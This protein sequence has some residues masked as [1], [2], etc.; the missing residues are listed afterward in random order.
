MENLWKSKKYL[1]RFLGITDYS[2]KNLKFLYLIIC[3]EVNL[4]LQNN[5]SNKK[6]QLLKNIFQDQVENLD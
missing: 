6:F 2:P 4:V 1:T 3:Y 5:L